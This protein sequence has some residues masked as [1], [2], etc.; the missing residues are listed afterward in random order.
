MQSPYENMGALAKCMCVI[1]CIEQCCVVPMCLLCL[2]TCASMRQNNV[3]YMTHCRQEQHGR[4]PR[5]LPNLRPH[6]QKPHPLPRLNQR[7]L[8]PQILTNLVKWVSWPQFNGAHNV[9]CCTYNIERANRRSSVVSKFSFW[10]S[11]VRK[12][13][14]CFR[15]GTA[16][17]AQ[18]KNSEFIV[19]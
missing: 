15:F 14:R 4:F 5:S 12:C 16:I 1:F 7:P 19:Q 8:L 11:C 10:M 18:A 6:Q 9:F 3:S 17:Q 13:L 2:L